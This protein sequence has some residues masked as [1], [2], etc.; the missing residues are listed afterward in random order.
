MGAIKQWELPNGGSYHNTVRGLSP[1][2]VTGAPT[3]TRRVGVLELDDN[4]HVETGQQVAGGLARRVY[5][6]E[7]IAHFLL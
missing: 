6:S 5:K 7:Q 2:L 3:C 1:P 4:M